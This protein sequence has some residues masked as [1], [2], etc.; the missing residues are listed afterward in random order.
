MSARHD[1]PLA[2]QLVRRWWFKQ[3]HP[4]FEFDLGDMKSTGGTLRIPALDALQQHLF[5]DIGEMYLKTRTEVVRF[6][7]K[8]VA[9]TSG[10]EAKIQ[11]HICSKDQNS[12]RRL[13][14]KRLDCRVPSVMLGEVGLVAVVVNVTS[15]QP[16]VPLIDAEAERGVLC[17]EF[18]RQGRFAAAWKSH[19]QVKYSHRKQTKAAYPRVT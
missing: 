7:S 3:T 2:N 12:R 4:L 19:H 5:G 17:L 15:E 13:P 18:A 6:C 10:P 9:L 1:S 11:N 14:Q 8:R 16:N